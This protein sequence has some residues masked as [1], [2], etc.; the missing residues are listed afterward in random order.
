MPPEMNF[1]NKEDL[2]ELSDKT[3][4]LLSRLDDI[5]S[6]LNNQLSQKNTRKKEEKRQ[7]SGRLVDFT[8]SKVL[9][10]ELEEESSPAAGFTTMRKTAI[11]T[12][13]RFEAPQMPISHPS[14]PSHVSR[15]V[16]NNSA[17]GF[18][19]PVR[20][21]SYDNRDYQRNNY[22]DNDDDEIYDD[23]YESYENSELEDRFEREERQETKTQ[24]IPV[25]ARR[26][27]EKANRRISKNNSNANRARGNNS[28]NLDLER[29]YLERR[30][31]LG[32]PNGT[33]VFNTRKYEIPEKLD[34]LILFGTLLPIFIAAIPLVIIKSHFFIKLVFSCV[35]AFSSMFFS[36]TAFRI[37]KLS[38]LAEWMHSRVLDT[39]A[40][41][42]D[43]KDT[44]D[45]IASR[46]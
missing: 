23:E 33:S 3:E 35:F 13:H 29:N 40:D 16:I 46:K 8:G 36:Y 32:E 19:D 25:S 27:A 5:S 28:N 12:E 21:D 31:S 15:P 45:E 10:S 30:L 44:L 6:K 2:K 26:G 11:F 22:G 4:S 43:I 1:S 41:L 9:A 24:R 42:S 17:T 18:R 38:S 14:A 39:Q 7:Y 20:R 37:A 34:N